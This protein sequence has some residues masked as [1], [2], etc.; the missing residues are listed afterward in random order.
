ML[1]YKPDAPTS[2][3]QSSHGRLIVPDNVSPAFQAS[4]RLRYR[5]A[6]DGEKL[7]V[8]ADAALSDKVADCMAAFFI[9]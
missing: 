8:A 1:E 5:M 6:G 7:F 9:V 2:L 3:T 4:D